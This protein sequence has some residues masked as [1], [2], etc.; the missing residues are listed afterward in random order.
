MAFTDEQN[1]QIRN[2]LIREPALRHYHWDAK[3]LCGATGGGRLGSPRDRFINSLIPRSCCFHRA[4]GYPYRV[5][6]GGAE[7]LAGE[8]GVCPCRPRG[9]GDPGG[10]PVAGRDESF[11]FIEQDADFLLHRL[12]ENVKTAHYH[13]D[14]THIRACWRRAACSP[15]AAWRWPPPRCGA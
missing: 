5:L 7:V 13:D 10:V 14:E 2:D 12:P 6:C 1:E 3:N 9:R 11:V 15:R 4:G 8:C